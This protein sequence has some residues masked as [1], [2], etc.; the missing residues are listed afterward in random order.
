MAGRVRPVRSNSVRPGKYAVRRAKVRLDLWRRRPNRCR[1]RPA[2]GDGN[3]HVTL[4]QPSLPPLDRRTIAAFWVT[5]IANALIAEQLDAPALFSEAGLDFSALRDPDAR[6]ESGDVS[7]RWELAV[8]RSGN[9]AIGLAG[10]AGAGPGRYGVVAYS[11][12]SA[13]DL[14]GTLHRIV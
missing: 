3:H 10:A 5:G 12:V 6:L 13:P 7:R 4:R 1:S 14:L 9:P 8:A 11:L 2:T